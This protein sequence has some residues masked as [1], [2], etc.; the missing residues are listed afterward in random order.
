MIFNDE[1]NLFR[2]MFLYYTFLLRN[3]F[4]WF[5]R[6]FNEI[7]AYFSTESIKWIN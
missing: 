3:Q 1:E 7:P 2:S 5:D 6:Y 4:L